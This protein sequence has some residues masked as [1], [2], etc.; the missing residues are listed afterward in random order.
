MA[1][2]ESG[3][4]NIEFSP[5]EIDRFK[6][7]A[8]PV[9]EMP[10][11]AGWKEIP[12]EPIDEPLVPLGINSKYPIY[13]DS[14][15]SGERSS[16]PYGEGLGGSLFTLFIRSRVAEAMARVESRLPS[17]LHLVLMDSYRPLEVQKS[18]FDIYFTEL[19]RL[20][21]E[22]EEN[23][24]LTETQKYVSL[25]SNDPTKPSPHNTGGSIDLTLMTLPPEVED[26][27]NRID[28]QIQALGDEDSTESQVQRYNLISLHARLLNFGTNFDNGG[29][30]AALNYLE[31]L[32]R[33]RELSPEEVEA[34]QNRRLLYHLMTDI[35]GLQPYEDEWWHYNS[36]LSQMGAKTAGLPKAEYG[37]LELSEKN[38][39]FEDQRRKLVRE[40]LDRD[41]TLG[42]ADTIKPAA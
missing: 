7:T 20:R 2:T 22:W 4:S 18:L 35:A 32:A 8:I 24:L 34:Q 9:E 1:T 30:E 39:F 12:I 33:T 21:P 23:Q 16:S 11:V 42:L 6:A 36:P 26:Q 14:I 29:P 38:K 25:P 41:T 17:G 5:E 31:K 28:L 19:K 13:T 15:Y 3:P 27:I 40:K 10:S 37:G